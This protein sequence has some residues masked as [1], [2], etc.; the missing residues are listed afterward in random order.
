MKPRSIYAQGINV[1]YVQC[2]YNADNSMCKVL[3]IHQ[4]L[5]YINATQSGTHSFDMNDLSP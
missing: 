2:T 4:F 5:K 3:T 1:I